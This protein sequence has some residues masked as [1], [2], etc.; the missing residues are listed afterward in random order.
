MKQGY[1]KTKRKN[2]K[3]NRKEA[4]KGKLRL[5]SLPLSLYM[6][7]NLQ[8]NLQCPSCFRSDPQYKD[9]DWP[10]MSYDLFQRAA[11]ALFP[12]ALRV[13]LSGGGESLL[14]K[15]IDSMLALC[16]HYQARPILYTN[17][18][19]LTPDRLTLLAQAGTVLGLSIDAATRDTF[20]ALRYPAKWDGMV[21]KL[22][23]IKDMLAGDGGRFFPYIGA[24]IQQKN[25]NELNE[26]VELA[27]A[28]GLELIKFTKFEPYYAALRGEVPDA[29]EV[30]AALV[31]VYHK[32][33]QRRIR[34]YVPDYGKT[35]VSAILQE[36]RLRNERLA[37]RM[38]ADNPD[39]WVHYPD[40]RS[41]DCQIP[42]S[43][44]MVTPEGKL[45]PGCCSGFEL[46][47]LAHSRFEEIWN[48]QKYQQLR[49]TVNSS[50][51]M[52]FCRE[53]ACPFRK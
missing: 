35:A 15:D 30:A 2:Y 7:V 24:V 10:C 45:T 39:R 33:N 9:K 12:T 26:L 18:T 3:L 22:E 49:K 44:C 32:A 41:K 17:T 42:W 8:C 6:D 21:R 13:V 5:R 19:P 27:H 53:D 31:D 48:N 11:H 4:A 37:T 40:A 29:E 25:L 38:D 23:T 51:P 16:V 14:H 47:D 46:G 1:G 20:E 34:L 36:L 43:E 52:S 50:R 28:Y